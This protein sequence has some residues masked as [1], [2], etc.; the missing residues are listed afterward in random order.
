LPSE[1]RQATGRT[2]AHK[3]LALTVVEATVH[4]S[5]PVHRAVTGNP[6]LHK[7]GKSVSFSEL[8]PHRVVGTN[9]MDESSALGSSHSANG[10]DEYEFCF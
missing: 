10:H 8:A 4:V 5:D 3:G 6:A 9:W 1:I 2:P 7:Q